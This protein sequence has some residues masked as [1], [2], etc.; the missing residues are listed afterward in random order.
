MNE[1]RSSEAVE[2]TDDVAGH[3][4]TPV[5]DEQASDDVEGHKRTRVLDDA[6]QDDVAGHKR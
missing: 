4:R 1:Q 3:K 5:L 2:D 6:S